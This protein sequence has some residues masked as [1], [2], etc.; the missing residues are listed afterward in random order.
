MTWAVKAGTGRA[1][2]FATESAARAFAAELRLRLGLRPSVLRVAEAP[3]TVTPPCGACR[4]EGSVGG[5][6]CA[7]R[8]V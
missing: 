6:V 4:G 7:C 5:A 8:E 2:P 1:A 3:A